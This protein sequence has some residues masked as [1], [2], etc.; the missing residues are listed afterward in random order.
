LKASPEDY[1]SR[2]DRYA[3]SALRNKRASLASDIVQLERQ[4]RH[5]RESLVHVDATLRLLD[6]Q[7]EP[8]SIPNKRPVKRIKLF[9][10]GELG[11]LKLDVLRQATEPVST[12]DV[13]SAVLHAGGHGEDARRALAPRVRGNLAYIN[14]RRKV[15]KTDTTEG[16]L[17]SLP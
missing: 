5:C 4:L 1:R 13:T 6:P 16:G 10:Q 14:N 8:E 17:W 12:R 7:A 15:V 2:G 11:R 9:R 3:L